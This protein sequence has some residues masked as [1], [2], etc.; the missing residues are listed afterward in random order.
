MNHKL[1][2]TAAGLATAVLFA[3]FA[4][5]ASTPVVLDAES[6]SASVTTAEASP[7]RTASVS[8]R[9]HYT[10]PYFSFARLLPRRES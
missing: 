6:A 9:T 7:S 1:R 8:H 3:S 4:L 10:M 5:T 2:S